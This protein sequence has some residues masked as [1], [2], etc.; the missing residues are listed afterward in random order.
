MKLKAVIQKTILTVRTW[1]KTQ[2]VKSCK[3]LRNLNAMKETVNL[4]LKTQLFAKI[5]VREFRRG[6]QKWTIQR[7]WL[8]RV[9]KTK[10]NKNTTHYTCLTPLCANKHK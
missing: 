7:S 8:H 9:Y 10:K 6:N 5:N 1:Q 3:Y 4:T 2:E